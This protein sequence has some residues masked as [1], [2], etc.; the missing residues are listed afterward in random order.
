MV[1][2]NDPRNMSVKS[3]ITFAGAG[4]C[5]NQGTATSNEVD[6]CG[7]GELCI[8]VTADE[9]SRD[10]AGTLE[11]SGATVSV[12][13]LGGVLMVQSEASQ[14]WDYGLIVYVGA[15][16]QV[17]DSNDHTSKIL[18]IYVGEGGAEHT[19]CDAG[20]LIPVATHGAALS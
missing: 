12:Y 15:A 6:V 19:N 16:G 1:Q 11:T 8:G 17:I 20:T 9:S 14:T 5:V 18:G 7:D 10:A 13:P 4:L 3:T 2:F